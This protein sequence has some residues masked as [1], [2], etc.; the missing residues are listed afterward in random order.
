MIASTLQTKTS[1]EMPANALRI[2]T[3]TGRAEDWFF[4]QE[5]NTIR[6]K[7]A[8]SCLIEPQLGDSV[9]IF[10]AGLE[11]VSF[12]TAVL[13]I[14]KEATSKIRLP[15]GS[16]LETN[17][18][19]LTIKAENIS[20]HGNASVSLNATLIDVNAI[21]GTIKVSHWQ[22]WSES[23]ESHAVRATFAIK[24]LTTHVNQAISRVRNSWRK[25]DE[26]DETHA[27]RVRICVQGHHQINAE[28]VTTQAKGFV[29]ID[30][31][32]IDLG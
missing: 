23:I 12:I 25:V 7:R 11:N 4:I 27:G 17:E 21:A 29:R 15:G 16:S 19:Q 1:A 28:H 2:A 14:S 31:K 24:T 3:V 6:L 13:V 26:L 22:S 9:L 10:D 20:I 8:A 32:K 30:G 5:P 18:Q